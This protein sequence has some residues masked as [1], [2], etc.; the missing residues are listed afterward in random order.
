MRAHDSRAGGVEGHQPHAPHTAS[1]QLLDTPA[2]LLCRL[3]R[4]GDRE[5]LARMGLS[6]EDQE[7]D[8]MGEY[9]RLAAAGAGKDQQRPLT[10]GYGLALWLVESFKQGLN[11]LWILFRRGLQRRGR[12]IGQRVRGS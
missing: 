11:A 5:D 2:H 4:E 9:S 12:M 1:E 7:G 10:V 8:A 6:R 3:V